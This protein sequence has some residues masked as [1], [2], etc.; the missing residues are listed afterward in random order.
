[1]LKS[2]SI[3]ATA[4]FS[5]S[6]LGIIVARN[7]H[8][9]AVVAPGGYLDATIDCGPVPG[10]S[11]IY[12][13]NS[14]YFQVD[15]VTVQGCGANSGGISVYGVGNKNVGNST[16]VINSNIASSSGPGIFSDQSYRFIIYKTLIS[17]S[18]GDGILITNRAYGT[19]ITGNIISNCGGDGVYLGEGTTNAVVRGNT[20][21][22]N[23][24]S[25]IVL[26]NTVAQVSTMSTMVT[27]QILKNMAYSILLSV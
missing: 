7:A 25:G 27:N 5:S 16:S 21:S 9:S 24:G 15:G 12:I 14:S 6:S 1:V 13:F 19:V 22:T 26:S 4:A 8:F 11:G 18:V 23:A 2:A 20:I 17:N 3:T 10:P